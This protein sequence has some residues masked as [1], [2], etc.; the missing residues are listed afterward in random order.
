M[1]YQKRHTLTRVKLLDTN[2]VVE[3][4]DLLSSQFTVNVN[5]RIL[6][7]F[8]TDRGDAWEIVK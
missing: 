2:E 4:V 6:F 1:S 8:Y 5:N 3:V 7:L